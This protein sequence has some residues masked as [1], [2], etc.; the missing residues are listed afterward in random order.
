MCI[1]ESVCSAGAAR[2]PP[3]QGTGL[4]VT[5]PFMRLDAPR[6]SGRHVSSSL[7]HRIGTRRTAAGA[8][9]GNKRARPGQVQRAHIMFPRSVAMSFCIISGDRRAGRIPAL[10][11]QT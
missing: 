11:M 6:R 10:I 8:L 4:A 2:R 9:G 1:R 3:G 5:V 7:P